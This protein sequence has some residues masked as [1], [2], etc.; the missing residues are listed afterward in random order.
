[1]TESVFLPGDWLLVI[2]LLLTVLSEVAVLFGCGWVVFVKGHSPW[3]FALA[4]AYC[5]NITILKALA[6][7]FGVEK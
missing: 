3:W 4:T 7:R 6:K 1:M 2:W 5:C